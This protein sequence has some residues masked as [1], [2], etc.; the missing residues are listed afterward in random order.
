[1]KKIAFINQRYGLEVNGGSEY[2]TR[3]IAERLSQKYD[4]SVLTTR[5][6]DY[7]TW[8]NFYAQGKEIINNVDVIRFSVDQCRD[9]DFDKF[10]QDYMTYIQNHG[11]NI[12]IEKK[13]FDKQGPLSKDLI[14]YISD[15]KDHYDVFIFVTYLYYHSVKGLPIVANKSIFIPT[16]HEEPYIHFKTFENIFKLPRAFVFLTE[17]EKSIVHNIFNNDNIKSDVL[18]TGV[19]IPESINFDSIKRKYNI[20]DYIIYVGRIDEGKGCLDLFNYFIEYKRRNNNNL[21]LVLMGKAVMSVPEHNDIINLGFV[22]EEEKF[23]GIVDALSL[24]MPSKFES[25]S[26]VI[27]ESMAVGVPVVVNA[28]CKV[29][30]GHCIKS[31]A[32]LFYED[33]YE[34]EGVINYLINNTDVYSQM[35]INAKRYVDENYQWSDILE[36]FGNIIEYVINGAS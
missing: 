35:K 9:K 7:V 21:K 13:W 34:F 27:L 3:L 20:D 15:N 19:D 18:G 23:G 11:R 28:K 16:A 31:N 25:L 14:R 36:R 5:A 17:E 22:S 26:M 10:N 12:E 32:G 30:K 29:L 8:D 4:V 1:M 6:I 2:Y 24:V 33:Y